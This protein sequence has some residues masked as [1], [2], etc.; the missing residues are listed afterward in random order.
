MQIVAFKKYNPYAISSASSNRFRSL[1]E[2]VVDLGASVDL[3]FFG[4]YL[5]YKEKIDFK[6]SGNIGEIN[7]QYLNKARNT[8]I[9]LRRINTYLLA[10]LHRMVISHKV[11]KVGNNYEEAILWL[12]DDI[13]LQMALKKVEKK[14]NFYFVEMNEF[15]DI[16]KYHKGNALQRK[17]ADSSQHFFEHIT[18]PK[19]D[20]MA[21]MTKALLKH[22]EN[23]PLPGPKLFHLPMTVDMERFDLSAEYPLPKELKRPYIAFVGVMCNVKDG[24]DILIDAFAKLTVDFPGLNLYMFGPWHYD[25]PGH[26]TQIKHLKLED[27][28][29]YKGMVSREEIPAI[30]MNATVLVLPRPD[31]KQARGGFPTKLGEYL[32]TGNPVCAT[33]VGELPDYLVD[34][35]SVYFAEPGSVD[36]FADAMKRALRNPEEARKI[37]S[38][39][40][41]I[42]ETHF[43]KD[44][45][46]KR[47]YEFLQ[48]NYKNQ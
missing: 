30:I 48:E 44:V 13:D 2:G 8:N 4:G 16:H 18:Y 29:Y 33:S 47:L 26:I 28:I 43:S 12:T 32:A 6:D 34:G 46:S 45:Q 37:G 15:L 22:Y 25:L 10:R 42:A 40:R 11:K 9:W 19:L 24:V 21:V 7:Y 5:S 41:K 1:I 27:K 3:Y 20:G 14:N 38:N 23:F 17:L 36:S 31:S 39:G 35:E